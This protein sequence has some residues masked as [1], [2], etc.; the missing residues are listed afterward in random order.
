M[1]AFWNKVTAIAFTSTSLAWSGGLGLD[2]LIR[3]AL[4]RNADLESSRLQLATLAQDTLAAL[5]PGNPSLELEAFHNLGDPAQ[6]KASVRLTQEFRP[7]YRSR[8]ADE[9]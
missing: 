1:R 6:P 7:G 9:A 8:A 3:M 2:S 5:A 4:E